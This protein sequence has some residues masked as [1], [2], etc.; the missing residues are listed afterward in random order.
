ML[1]CSVL[2]QRFACAGMDRKERVSCIWSLFPSDINC[3]ATIPC[4]AL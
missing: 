4:K 1:E 3:M 2:C